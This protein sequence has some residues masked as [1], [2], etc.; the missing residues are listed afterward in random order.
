MH[1]DAECKQKAYPEVTNKK[2]AV[3]DK[4]F[5]C[6]DIKMCHVFKSTLKHPQQKV[7]RVE[8]DIQEAWP[9]GLFSKSHI[10]FILVL[11]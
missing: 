8:T 3:K 1:I 4:S 6:S 11:S 7:Q 5:K 9:F 10:C 2:E